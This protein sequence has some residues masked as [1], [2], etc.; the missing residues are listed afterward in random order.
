MKN[1]LANE[2][3]VYLKQ[4][5][6]NPVE[7]QTWCKDTLSLAKKL[8]KPI[9]VSVGYS[10]CH[11]CHVMERESFNDEFIAKIMNENFVCVKV[12]R[13]ERPDLDYI[14]MQSVLMMNGSGGWP[15]NVFCLPNGSPFFGGT[16]FPP[17]DI[18]NGLIPW[19][20]LLIRISE[21]F[22]NSRKEL[23]ENSNS[24]RKNLIASS[25]ANL[26]KTNF[27]KDNLFKA[28]DGI[29]GNFDNQY[30]GLG[31]APKFPHPLTLNFILA[32]ASSSSC[33]DLLRK[34][35]FNI[36]D[37]TLRAMSHGGIFDQIGG[38][39]FRYSVD[40]YWLIPHFEK[41]LYDNA[42]LI[43]VFV[44]NWLQTKDP[45]YLSIINESIEWLDREMVLKDGIYSASIN[46]DSDGKEGVYYLWEP[47]QI[48]DVLGVKKAKD[49]CL[50]FG[51]TD[52]G[53][54]E[55]GFSNPA[56]QETEFKKRLSY[57][58]SIEK[59]LKFREENRTKPRID[60]KCI[61]SWNC[62]LAMSLV[63]A[64]FYLDKK[65]LVI[66]SK[67]ILDFILA[68]FIDQNDSFVTLNSIFY[69]GS[70]ANNKGFL[71]DYA[72]L[73][74]ALL[75]LSSKIDYFEIGAS[76]YYIDFAEKIMKSI[77]KQFNDLD[78]P[79]FYY[80]SIDDDNLIIRFKEW[81]DDAVPSGNSLVLHSLSSL[82]YLRQDL[83]YEKTF[84]AQSSVYEEGADLNAS[85]I[86]HALEAIVNHDNIAVIKFSDPGMILNLRNELLE[87]HWRK[88]FIIYDKHASQTGIDL[89]IGKKCSTSNK[90]LKVLLSD[91]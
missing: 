1:R 5:A 34:K 74:E 33:N 76:K 28:L 18:G 78:S 79:G 49:F 58:D 71:H 3:S 50:S 37:C 21:F 4:H 73:C 47:K 61:V 83:F 23:E 90:D 12:D 16:Y 39:F 59:L 62:F 66:K 9:I 40:K 65:D 35:A 56:L 81:F 86:S 77:I 91:Y 55:N 31:S 75:A 38:G 53:N 10:S 17:E 84:Y 20:Q 26:I 44:R 60:K 30:G 14:F 52:K 70:P 19:P 57:S 2:D 8:D 69:E 7:W 32:M 15:L 24:I 54:F 88:L 63:E 72:S 85:S 80:N 68:K 29:L 22:K 51:I 41:M 25:T 48:S 27:N 13:E 42:L 82:Y 89:C 6:N 67:K 64:G 45:L 43:N 11:W 36:V 46:A 87:R